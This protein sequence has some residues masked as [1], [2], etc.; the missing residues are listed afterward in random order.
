[1]RRPGH[2]LFRFPAIALHH[3]PYGAAGL[4]DFFRFQNGAPDGLHLVAR[5]AQKLAVFVA[6]LERLIADAPDVNRAD[7]DGIHDG[8]A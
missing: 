2:K 4:A 8:S 3:D 7:I 6:H 1:M 5:G